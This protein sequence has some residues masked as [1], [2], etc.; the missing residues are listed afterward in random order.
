VLILKL[1]FFIPSNNS[2][3]AAYFSDKLASHAPHLTLD[4]LTEFAIGF[5]KATAA[6]QVASLNYLHPWVSNLASFLD[7]SSSLFE[8]SP[9]VRHCIRTL[10]DMTV[11]NSEVRLILSGQLCV[12][13]LF[14]LVLPSRE[15]ARMGKF[16]QIKLRNG[17]C[18]FG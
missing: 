4:F 12:Y 3:F 2:A 1:G 8:P 5:N 9:K 6:Q 18:Y 16:G 11:K 10:I 14:Y 7:P 17:E 13:L 15:Q